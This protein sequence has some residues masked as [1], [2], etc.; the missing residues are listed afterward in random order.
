[1][2]AAEG[3]GAKVPTTVNGFACIDLSLSLALGKQF[4]LGAMI[5]FKKINSYEYTIIK[6]F[7]EGKKYSLK[8][9]KKSV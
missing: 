5:P 7:N 2:R 1:M 4:C 8:Y 6:L 9:N 3:P